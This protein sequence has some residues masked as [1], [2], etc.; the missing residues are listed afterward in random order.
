MITNSVKFYQR[1]KYNPIYIHLPRLKLG[2][3]NLV[4]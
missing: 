3:L 1:K 2:G 4:N